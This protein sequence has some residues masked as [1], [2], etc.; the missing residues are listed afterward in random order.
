MSMAR[1]NRFGYPQKSFAR[2]ASA[3]KLNSIHPIT[4]YQKPQPNYQQGQ[5]NAPNKIGKMTVQ[6]VSYWN[7]VQSSIGC[8]NYYRQK[9]WAVQKEVFDSDLKYRRINDKDYPHISDL[10][11][12][13]RVMKRSLLPEQYG[14][15][16]RRSGKGSKEKEQHSSICIY[17]RMNL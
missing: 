4:F 15:P 3:A 9:G 11:Y 1:N 8:P 2:S 13:E 12:S 16:R 5:R 6:N 17:I 10:D 14:K 7:S